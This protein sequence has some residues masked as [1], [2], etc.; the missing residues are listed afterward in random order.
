MSEPT[1]DCVYCQ[2]PRRHAARLEWHT[3]WAVPPPPQRDAVLCVWTKE[4]GVRAFVAIWERYGLCW[5]WGSTDGSD[6]EILVGG[7][8]TP[9]PL[10]IV[11]APDNPK[12]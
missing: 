12:D 8:K 3:P 11:R 2:C 9:G 7:D 1:S 4:H 5:R 6:A 10:V